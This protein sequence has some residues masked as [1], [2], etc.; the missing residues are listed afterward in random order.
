MDDA[1][2]V[3]GPYQTDSLCLK[4]TSVQDLMASSSE[5]ADWKHLVSLCPSE[6][7]GEPSKLVKNEKGHT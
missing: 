7:V 3:E 1:L 4:K 2:L 5:L 6:G